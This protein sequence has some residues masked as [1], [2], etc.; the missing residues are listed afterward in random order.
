[1]AE[2][3]KKVEVRYGAFACTIEGYDN[4]VEQ[5]RGILGEMQQMIAATPQLTPISDGTEADEIEDALDSSEQAEDASPGIVVIRDGGTAPAS[6][7]PA[8]SDASDA[9]EIRV[10]IAGA[11]DVDAADRAEAEAAHDDGT[12][13]S[14][15][16]DDEPD[17]P[18][19]AKAEVE[20][21]VDDVDPADPEAEALVETDFPEAASEP[22]GQDAEALEDPDDEP[23]IAA[24]A[25]DEEDEADADS[26]GGISLAAAAAAGL[27]VGGAH[28]AGA[29]SDEDDEPDEST[30]DDAASSEE[31][32]AL[33]DAWSI[34][35]DGSSITSEA[36]HV[37]TDATDTA[38]AEPEE[39][40]IFADPDAGSEDAEAATTPEDFSDPDTEM[41]R[42]AS[43]TP[44]IFADPGGGSEPPEDAAP[45][46]H[47]DTND[48]D[49]RE[50]QESDD[51]TDE[52][53]DAG[54]I[55]NIF[56]APPTASEPAEAEVATEHGDLDEKES[57]RDPTPSH[58]EPSEIWSHQ[59]EPSE[60]STDERD[61]AGVDEHVADEVA[62]TYAA[63]VQPKTAEDVN[64]FATP[65]SDAP[66]PL[67]IFAAPSSSSD[68]DDETDTAEVEIDGAEAEA[69]PEE[70]SPE[71]SPGG[72]N[73]FSA[74][75]TDGVAAPID[76]KPEPTAP[77][78][79]FAAAKS[80][81]SAEPEPAQIWDQ[82]TETL[83]KAAPESVHETLDDLG[84]TVAQYAAT[85]QEESAD[86]ALARHAN[87]DTSSDVTSPAQERG[88][89]EPGASRFQALLDSVHGNQMVAA[90]GEPG[91]LTAENEN[92]V[93]DAPELPSGINSPDA[94]A[95]RAGCES[96]SD[97]LAA[98]AA[99][100]TLAKGKTRFSRREVMD[101]FE[102]IPGDHPRTLEARI[103]GYGRLVRSGM[104]V[105]V[106]DGVFAMAQ[107]ERDRFQT[108][109]DGS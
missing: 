64:I 90:P 45:G 30:S 95:T 41:V 43:D 19:S 78:N 22:H 84:N 61:T 39:P 100:L 56:A 14:F 18:D 109:L 8:E 50:A 3:G 57:L 55:A 93:N 1:M 23:P 31:A 68:Q 52:P 107:T 44:N 69:A 73:I 81:T 80:E 70:S 105:L 92:A 65:E 33:D 5:L 101:V 48:T 2:T 59:A 12:A 58:E 29:F 51:H 76:T 102:T 10:P 63:D 89:D 6:T 42:E 9:E 104:L 13:T 66:S 34:P 106:D 53:A 4:P 11:G 54:S 40:N 20:L 37:G 49:G 74:P 26:A 24:A 25:T 87:S 85:A 86:A 96:V 38:P 94:L 103:K 88:S 91:T 75:P 97:L 47:E 72:V 16:E 83:A 46:I 28:L 7:A 36:D 60:G 27:A 82:A 15:V 77:V 67:N 98:S 71:A 21:S 108:I 17:A 99:W 79:I 35:D 32:L 62:E